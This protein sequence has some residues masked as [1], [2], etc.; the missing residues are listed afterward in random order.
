MG[1]GKG[2]KRRSGWTPRSHAAVARVFRYKISSPGRLGKCVGE[3]PWLLDR[4]PDGCDQNLK[5]L[6]R[7]ATNTYFPQTLTVISSPA[8]EDELTSLVDQLSGNLANVKTVEHVAAA[9]QFNPKV[10]AALGASATATYSNEGVASERA[11][12]LEMPCPPKQAGSLTY[13]PAAGTRLASTL[14]TPSFTRAH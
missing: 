9:K 14:L 5:L 8:E 3:R 4:D 1:S 7:T 6:I 13:L 12:S 2:H 10:S 11:S